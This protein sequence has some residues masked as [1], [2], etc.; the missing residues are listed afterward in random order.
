MSRRGFTLAE[1]LIATIVLAILGTVLTRLL[2]DDSRFV[3]R[4][5]A[6]MSARQAARAA[7]NT[8]VDELRMVSDGGLIAASTESVRVRMPYVFGM[9]CNTVSGNLI[10]SMTPPDSL[11]YAN[12][13]SDG[14]ARRT[15][16][17]YVFVSGISVSPSTDM[18]A[19]SSDSIRVVPGGRLVEISGITP[20]QMPTPG[21]LIYLYQDVTYRFDTSSDLPGRIG[22]WRRAG[23]GPAEELVAPFDTL[24]GFH[25]LVG[26]GLQGM[27]C[28][29]PGG[30][31]A[32]R[33]LELRLVGASEHTPR[34]DASPQTFA[35]AT[36]VT[37]LNRVN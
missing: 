35:V 31:P 4:Q 20:P 32:V 17:S 37:F 27:N 22:L 3:S 25:C 29:P 1:L 26:P 11:M 33:G 28:P 12:T 2:I 15:G 9:A 36:R 34:G 19:C 8:M 23:S 18:A 16:T 10:A 14:L 30:L 13:S 7:L 6:M 5:D 24:A 21:T